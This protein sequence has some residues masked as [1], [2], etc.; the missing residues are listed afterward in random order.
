MKQI[1]P[2]PVTN[3]AESARANSRSW[4]GFAIRFGISSLLLIAV[5]RSIDLAPIEESLGAIRWEWVGL[6]VLTLVFQFPVACLRWALILRPAGYRV[7]VQSLQRYV[8]IGQLV[9]QVLPT[10]IGGDAVRAW[11]VI[12]HGVPAG[13]SIGSVVWDRIFGAVGVA[14]MFVLLAPALTSGPDWSAS[15]TSLFVIAGF[16]PVGAFVLLFAHRLPLE[17]I[18]PHAPHALVALA[19][20]G[21]GLLHRPRAVPG[22]IVLAVCGNLLAVLAFY[23]LAQAFSIPLDALTA[24]LVVPP[25]LLATMLPI[26]IAGWGVREGVLLALLSGAGLT[27]AQVFALSVAFGLAFVV[28]AIPGAI[29][30]VFT[31]KPGVPIKS[32]V[33]AAYSMPE[34]AMSTNNAVQRQ[35]VSSASPPYGHGRGRIFLLLPMLNEADNVR[36]LLARIRDCLKG[37]DYTVCVVDDGSK[38]GTREV[39]EADLKAGFKDLKLI[40]RTKTWHGSQR[41]GALY[42]ALLA[43]LEDRSVSVF[44]EMDG[45]LSHRPEELPMGLSLIER[46]V[47]DIAIASKYAAGGK[48]SDR[49]LA[50]RLVSRICNYAVRGLI[51]HRVADYSNGYRFYGRDAAEVL[52]F[53]KMR[54]ASPIYLTEAMAIW[55][56]RRLLIREFPSHYVGRN[57]GISKLRVLD[58]VKASLAIFE[59]AWRYHFSGFAVRADF[60]PPKADVECLDQDRRPRAHGSSS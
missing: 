30:W 5:V 16:L 22:I 40:Y 9:N 38:D 14:L 7:P 48:I 2:T 51:T 10:F 11:Y 8:W 39:L 28:A 15:L 41:G 34:A 19:R 54:Y 36:N 23:L 57:E 25:V 47:A 37:R 21:Q 12:G 13:S 50:R 52:A 17:R 6:A 49:P 20:V 46:G 35:V 3:G 56:D 43:G 31:P 58:L 53:T 55:L 26:S 4:I 45:D 33:G 44:I 27:T 1:D 24:L 60:A 59:I 32:V 18:V 29:I 42:A